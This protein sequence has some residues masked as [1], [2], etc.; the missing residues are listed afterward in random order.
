P[1]PSRSELR[2]AVRIQRSA[3]SRLIISASALVL[4]GP[5]DPPN[6]NA[7]WQRRLN[8][9]SS[10]REHSLFHSL[11]R[12]AARAGEEATATGWWEALCGCLD[13]RGNCSANRTACSRTDA[14]RSS[15]APNKWD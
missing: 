1:A 8:D 4:A 10:A 15:S 6:V 12:E 9:G 5:P 2:T 7:S 13:G 14:S 3:A 11:G